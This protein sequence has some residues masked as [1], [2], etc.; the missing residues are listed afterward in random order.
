[1][2]SSCGTQD[3]AGD[4]LLR[5]WGAP[6][7]KSAPL[8]LVSVQP[9]KPRSA[10]V[11]L[12]GAGAGPPPSKQSALGPYPTKS[13]TVATN[14]QPL[15]VSKVPS[16]T[17]ATLPAVADIAML[18]TASGRGSSSEPPEPAASWIR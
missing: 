18:P 3:C 1:M 6:V 4:A 8:L 14:G 12:P 9:A 2:A 7:T 11:V 15:P 17:S 10:A 5:G 13:V 16:L